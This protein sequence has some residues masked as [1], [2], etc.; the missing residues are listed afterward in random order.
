MMKELL[1]DKKIRLIF[2]MCLCIF[3]LLFFSL[4]P[5]IVLPFLIIFY[6]STTGEKCKDL[7]PIGKASSHTW[8]YCIIFL[9]LYIAETTFM[10]LALENRELMTS[11]MN[12]SGGE[13]IAALLIGITIG[14]IVA[15]IS[16]ELFFRGIVYQRLKKMGFLPALLLSSAI[17]GAMHLK[18][19]PHYIL[20]GILLAL[21]FE[22]SQS[23]VVPIVTHA[24]LSIVG[25]AYSYFVLQNLP[26]ATLNFL[27]EYS[28]LFRGGTWVLLIGL[29]WVL[30]RGIKQR[31]MLN[32][33]TMD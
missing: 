11:Q 33:N 3:I 7:F 6:T 9:L 30:Y 10:M 16:E 31:Q 32:E 29:A 23:I 4:A 18:Y 28:T 8:R 15:A 22:Y 2:G 25:S 19:I 24:L 13:N 17:F 5:S 20:T 26:E 14:A 21:L 1:Q 12:S 27:S